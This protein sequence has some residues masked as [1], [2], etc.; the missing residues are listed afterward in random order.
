MSLNQVGDWDADV[1]DQLAG[2]TGIAWTT[3]ILAYGA[4]VLGYG[5]GVIPRFIVD[6]QLLLVLGC[7]FF[8]ATIGLDK[9]RRIRSDGT[10]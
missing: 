1:L 7:V 4:T 9:L 3:S 2:L 10:L 5:S 8:V 6:R